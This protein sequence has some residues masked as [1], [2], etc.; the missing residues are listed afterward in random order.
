MPARVQFYW[1]A[2]L[3]ISSFAECLNGS[4]RDHSLDI[5]LWW[6]H[7]LRRFLFSVQ[8]PL[9]CG[10]HSVYVVSCIGAYYWAL[11][12]NAMVLMIDLVP[13]ILGLLRDD[14]RD[15]HF[16]F[17]WWWTSGCFFRMIL[18]VTLV[19]FVTNCASKPMPRTT[20]SWSVGH[21]ACCVGK[22][23]N[24]K[25]VLNRWRDSVRNVRSS[26]K[27]VEEAK[28]KKMT[29][30]SVMGGIWTPGQKEGQCKHSLPLLN[31]SQVLFSW[32]KVIFFTIFQH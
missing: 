25:T 9:R 16:R 3:I 22:V 30:T 32:K 20:R 7:F 23:W 31:Q 5:W 26:C 24:G 27:A 4:G 18:I 6:W 1:Q 28:P 10:M 19:L 13:R 15:C 29:G 2:K 21:W 11:Q 17:T 12:H 14:G 8:I